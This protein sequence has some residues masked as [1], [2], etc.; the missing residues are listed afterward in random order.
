MSFGDPERHHSD[1]KEQLCAGATHTLARR[2][3]R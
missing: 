2:L 1:P 3:L